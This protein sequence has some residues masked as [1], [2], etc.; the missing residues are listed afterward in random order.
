[1]AK[2]SPKDRERLWK[3]FVV[4][5]GKAQ[6]AYDSAMLKLGAAGL[7]LTVSLATALKVIGWSGETAAILF[8]VSLAVSVFSYVCVQL[9]MRARLDALRENAEY[10]GAER[11]RWTTATWLCNLAAGVALL[12]GAALLA[13]FIITSVKEVNTMSDKSKSTANQSAE[14]ATTTSGGADDQRGKTVIVNI[15]PPPEKKK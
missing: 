8:L 12:A 1:M 3:Q 4:E 10:E 14:K 7:A 5:H 2:L 6:E 11:T 15:P 13:V 9:D